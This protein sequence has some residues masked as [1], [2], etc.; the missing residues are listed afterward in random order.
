LR[1]GADAVDFKVFVHDQKKVEISW[2]WFRCDKAAP[3]EDPPQLSAASRELQE[4]PEAA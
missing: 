1:R 2:G 4:F 3:N